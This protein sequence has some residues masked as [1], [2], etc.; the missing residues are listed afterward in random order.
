MSYIY[1]VVLMAVRLLLGVC[2]SFGG[3]VRDLDFF[4]LDYAKYVVACS[5]DGKMGLLL[6]DF[7]SG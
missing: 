4:L 6:V 7:E 1:A 3:I 2:A 5:A